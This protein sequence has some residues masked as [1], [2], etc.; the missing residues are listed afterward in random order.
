MSHHKNICY[1]PFI[2][3]Y[4]HPNDGPQ[5][6]CES[7]ATR[8]KHTP[9]TLDLKKD[10]QSK[11]F[12]DIRKRMLAG[13]KLSICSSCWQLEGDGFESDRLM[14]NHKYERHGSPE[15][16]IVKG[17]EIGK[18]LDLD[19]RPTNLCNLKCRMCTP[20]YSSQLAKES[21]AHPYVRDWYEGGATGINNIT[22][23]DIMTEENIQHLISGLTPESDIKFLGGEPTIMPEV[24]L[25]LDRLIEADKTDCFISLTTNCTNF[26]NQAMFDKLAKFKGV[27]AQL[28][29]DGM[30]KT[31]E[32][33]RHP[34]NW[35][36]AQEVI[37][38]WIDITQ[39]REI[40]F[41]LQS[42]NLFNVYDFLFWLADFNKAIDESKITVP[43]EFYIIDEP[44]WAQIRNLP[45]DAR[46]KEVERISSITDP[47]VIRLMNESEMPLVLCLEA[48]LKDDSYVRK[49]THSLARATKGFDTARKQHIKDYI[50]AVYSQIKEI[51]SQ[52]PTPKTRS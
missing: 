42:L 43:V 10:W 2:H 1:A 9:E 38:Q 21:K 22:N 36:R 6:C 35:K 28:S 11:Y 47:Y 16:D 19:I 51:Y 26:N 48:L 13:E 17:T 30:G 7:G 8:S 25:M 31:V 24:S 12:Q 45:V 27:G 34:L 44:N 37:T 33:I 23:Y 32:Y 5:V 29:L 14:F 52:L 41:V 50:P 3:R 15:L 49:G 20:S 40:H 4:V 39:N 18:P 46:H